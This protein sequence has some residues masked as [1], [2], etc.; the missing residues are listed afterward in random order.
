MPKNDV[1]K[2]VVV[3]ADDSCAP[4]RRK[5]HMD[6]WSLVE[7]LEQSMDHHLRLAYKRWR[8]V[9]VGRKAGSTPQVI[10]RINEPESDTKSY[11]NLRFLGKECLKRTS[12]KVEPRPI[13]DLPRLETLTHIQASLIIKNRCH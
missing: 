6:K 8:K 1:N 3:S 11:V 7:H 9:S 5:A 13:G 12:S 2:I 4:L 10:H